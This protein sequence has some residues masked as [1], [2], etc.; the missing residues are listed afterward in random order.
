MVLLASGWSRNFFPECVGLI[1]SV[2]VS[3]LTLSYPPP[4]DYRSPLTRVALT[5]VLGG[6]LGTRKGSDLTPAG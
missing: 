3:V 2:D 4:L 5:A 1:M 6:M